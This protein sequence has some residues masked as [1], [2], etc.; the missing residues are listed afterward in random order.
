MQ[1]ELR[2]D[3]AAGLAGLERKGGVL[4]TLDHH[5]AAEQA[6]IAALRRRAR[7]LRVFL[8]ELGELLGRRL[9]FCE[10][11]LGLLVRRLAR[12]FVRIGRQL[13]QD[14]ARTPLLAN[15]ILAT[16]LRVRFLQLRV[17]HRGCLAERLGRE[18]DVL[19]P[20]PFGRSIFR[21]VRFVVRLRLLGRD[22]HLVEV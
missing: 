19:D 6:E 9:H 22:R 12:G 4:E 18:H 17:R 1:T 11:L 15:A 5:P 16:R 10:D 13:D 3:D 14:V 8:R 21:F 20:N 2:L 7:V